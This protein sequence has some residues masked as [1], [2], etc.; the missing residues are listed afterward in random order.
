MNNVATAN[1]LIQVKVFDDVIYSDCFDIAEISSWTPREN[2]Y[3]WFWGPEP[4]PKTLGRFTGYDKQVVFPDGYPGD[5]DTYVLSPWIVTRFKGVNINGEAIWSNCEPF[6]DSTEGITGTAE[7]PILTCRRV[8][9][10]DESGADD[11]KRITGH[12]YVYRGEDIELGPFDIIIPFDS[13]KK[14][15]EQEFDFIIMTYSSKFKFNNGSTILDYEYK[16]SS[17]GFGSKNA[18]IGSSGSLT[19]PEGTYERQ[20]LTLADTAEKI[21]TILNAGIKKLLEKAKHY[22]ITKGE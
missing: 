14:I 9:A 10:H 15:I 3:C 1:N 13:I 17:I 2:E 20:L 18:S 21:T 8:Y 22:P 5:G 7:E 4:G 6:T 16:I 19:I 11:L 12:R